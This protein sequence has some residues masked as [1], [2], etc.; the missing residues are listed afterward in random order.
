MPVEER[1]QQAAQQISK[2]PGP[3]VA[4]A[5]P[6]PANGQLYGECDGDGWVDDQC[7]PW[8]EGSCNV[9]EDGDADVSGELVFDEGGVGVR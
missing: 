9:V 1:R 3:A 2:E 4:Q 6:L 5:A 8:G 7:C